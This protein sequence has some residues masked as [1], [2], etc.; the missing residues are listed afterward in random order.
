MPRASTARRADHTDQP[1][2]HTNAQLRRLK[3]IREYLRDFNAT[4]AAIRAGYAES[5]ASTE[6]YRLLRNAQVRAQIEKA[7]AELYEGVAMSKSEAIAI[8]SER[9]RG[10]IT[11]YQTMSADGAWT[12][13][14]GPDSPNTKAIREITSTTRYDKDG[15]DLSL[16]K[17]MKLHDATKAAEVLARIMGWEAKTQV[18]L[19]GTPE[20]LTVLAGLDGTTQGPPPMRAA[21][22]K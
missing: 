15:N 20:L 22:A 12:E 6:G 2:Q 1:A 21:A 18:E 5:G 7:K 3:F 4:K 8:L 17:T 10:D 14:V 9:A 11:D 19:S 13:D 16:S